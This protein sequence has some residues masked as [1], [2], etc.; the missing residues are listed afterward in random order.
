MK[1]RPLGS[2][3]SVT[4]LANSCKFCA[5]SSTGARRITKRK[6]R[7]IRTGIPVPILRYGDRQPQ[8]WY[9]EDLAMRTVLGLVLLLSPALAGQPEEA[10]AMARRKEALDILLKVL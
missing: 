5:H 8:D 7:R 3:N 9:H 2:V 1:C 4:F 10:A 6:G